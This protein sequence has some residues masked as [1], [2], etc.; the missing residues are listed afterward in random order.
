M[1]IIRMLV[2]HYSQTYIRFLRDFNIQLF[3]RFYCL[4]FIRLTRRRF[5]LRFER[6][7]GN[8]GR[9]VFVTVARGTQLRGWIG[10]ATSFIPCLFRYLRCVKLLL[11]RQV[12]PILCLAG[13]QVAFREEGDTRV[14][15]NSFRLRFIRFTR[16]ISRSKLF[17]NVF[18]IQILIVIFFVI[19]LGAR[20]GILRKEGVFRRL[21]GGLFPRLLVGLLHFL[22]WRR[23]TMSANGVFPREEGF[24]RGIS[25]LSG[26]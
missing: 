21:K 7:I 9:Q 19:F 3:H 10:R 8:R 1:R 25:P 4:L 6:L 2:T 15:V 5:L 24:I 17:R 20:S 26:F 22:A 16:L 23:L 12:G 18:P 13:G 14:R 11:T